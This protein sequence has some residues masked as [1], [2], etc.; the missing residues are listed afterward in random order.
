MLTNGSRDGHPMFEFDGRQQRVLSLEEIV[1]SGKHAVVV[2][3]WAF[4]I[5]IEITESGGGGDHTVRWGGQ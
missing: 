2:R 4:F 1:A 3:P 5:L